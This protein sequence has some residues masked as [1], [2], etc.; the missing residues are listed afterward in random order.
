MNM[1]I[2]SFKYFKNVLKTHK[3]IIPSSLQIKCRFKICILRNLRLLNLNYNTSVIIFTMKS[4]HDPLN[5]HVI[6]NIIDL[7]AFRQKWAAKTFV[8]VIL[9][10]KVII[11]PMYL[12]SHKTSHARLL[13]SNY[14]EFVL[15]IIKNGH[16]IHSMREC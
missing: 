7:S 2:N 13:S 3:H 11:K 10:L 16:Y 14:D 12:V 4:D 6:V 1:N 9:R 8:G 5:C 15:L